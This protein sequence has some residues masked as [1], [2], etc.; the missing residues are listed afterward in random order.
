MSHVYQAGVCRSGDMDGVA[1]HGM[2]S[3]VM[4]V[5]DV[6]GWYVMACLVMSCGG[7]N[8]VM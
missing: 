7:G 2:Y 5:M 6:M 3:R 8:H 4:H 1:C